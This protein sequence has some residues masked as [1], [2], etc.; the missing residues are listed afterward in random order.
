[1]INLTVLEPIHTVEINALGYC[2]CTFV[3]LS[4]SHSLVAVP[5]V[6]DDSLIDVIHLPSCKRVYR[7]IGKDA[8]D[9]KTGTVMAL[10]G[11]TTT[12]SLRV[13]ASYEDGRVAM[14]EQVGSP[15]DFAVG[16]ADEGE[17]WTKVFEEKH[18]REPSKLVSY[19]AGVFQLRRAAAMS[20]AVE[21]SRKQAWSVGADHLV[22]RYDLDDQV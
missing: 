13:A 22:A 4:A 2:K 8:L 5:A 12:T 10:A 6:L 18:H 15:A 3:P 7:S 20:I 19:V 1:M 9:G 16:K 14:F 17:G 11:Y 21:A